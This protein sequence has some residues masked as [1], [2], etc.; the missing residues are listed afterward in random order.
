VRESGIPFQGK[1]LTS[2]EDTVRSVMT[3]TRLEPCVA[4]GPR[5][6]WG[7]MNPDFDRAVVIGSQDPTNVGR[8][9]KCVS[10]HATHARTHAAH[11]PAAHTLANSHPHTSLT[12]LM[13]FS[14]MLR[15]CAAFDVDV[16]L[17]LPSAA[18]AFGPISIR[19]SAGAAFGIPVYPVADLPKVHSHTT[20][21]PT[22]SHSHNHTYI[23][24]HTHTNAF[25]LLVC[26]IAVWEE[27]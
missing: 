22:H 15:L 17:L 25:L 20:L 10:R 6:D 21:T 5:P 8:S 13:R 9:E 27:S 2:H 26:L 11:T 7:A 19:A 18:D 1:W 12:Y 3:V 24:T 23:H 4:F 14:S 16:V